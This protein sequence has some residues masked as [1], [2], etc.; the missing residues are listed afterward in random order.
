M[1]CNCGVITIT[2]CLCKLAPALFVHIR[3]TVFNLLLERA[4]RTQGLYSGF[5]H[6]LAHELAID[7]RLLGLRL[8]LG[9]LALELGLLLPDGDRTLRRGSCC[10]AYYRGS[11]A[12]LAIL[13]RPA[14]VRDSSACVSSSS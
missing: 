10:S 7:A 6:A 9:A 8:G 12:S 11:P 1:H 3:T 2:R 14:T 5:G 13:A 4:P